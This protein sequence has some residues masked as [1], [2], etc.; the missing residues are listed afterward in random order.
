ML[1]YEVLVGTGLLLLVV[2]ISAL[3]GRSESNLWKACADRV[4]C[5]VRQKKITDGE[6]H[7]R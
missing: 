4:S 5:L 7:L 6:G 3:A 1:S 2:G